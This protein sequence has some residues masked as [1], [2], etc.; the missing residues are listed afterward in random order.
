MHCR[1]HWQNKVKLMFE[2]ADTG[3][4]ATL[5]YV[6]LYTGQEVMVVTWA[7]THFKIQTRNLVLVAESY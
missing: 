3:A 2:C 4:A 7:I 1:W 5:R 6:T